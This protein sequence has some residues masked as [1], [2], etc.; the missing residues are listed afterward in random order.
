MKI[1]LEREKVE[2]AKLEAHAATMKATNEATQLSLTK[3]SQESKI[4]MADMDKMDPLARACHE[5][6]HERIGQE[7]MAARDG[8]ASPHAPPAFMSTPAP[9]VDPVVATELPP[10]AD[11]EVVKV[12]PSVTSIIMKKLEYKRGKLLPLGFIDPNTVHEVTV[13]DFAKDTE[14]NIVMFLE[15]Q[16]DKE[17]IFFPYNFNFHFILLIIDLHLGVVNVMDS[18]RTEYAEWADMAAILQRAWKRFINTVPGE[19]KPELTFRDY[20]CMRQ[21]KGNNLCG[22]YVCTFM[23][24]MSCPKGGDAQIHHTRMTRLRD[25]LIT[26]DQIKAIQE[27]IAGFFITEVLTPGGEHYRKIVTAEDIRS[28]KVVL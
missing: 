27:E 1:A 12:E 24:D 17:D 7:V 19:W 15:K 9:T 20:P 26:A 14:D 16:A 5:M 25:T 11:E 4:L 6:Y 10:A 21:E 22:Y 8:S 23:R 3:M 13:R 2:A 18:K 28:G